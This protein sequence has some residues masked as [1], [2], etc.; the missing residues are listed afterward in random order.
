MSETQLS[1]LFSLKRKTGFTIPY[2]IGANFFSNKKMI[3]VNDFFKQLLEFNSDKIYYLHYCP[4]IGEYVISV[5]HPI[6]RMKGIEIKNNQTQKVKLI[7]TQ[8]T[9]ILGK[10]LMSI[11]D[12]LSVRYSNYLIANKFSFSNRTWKEFDANEIAELKLL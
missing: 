8:S 2:L 3:T 4:D 11:T 5:S 1:N 7:L 6:F 9:E 10:D 12:K